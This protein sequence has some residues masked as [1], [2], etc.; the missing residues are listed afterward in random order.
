ME[1]SGDKERFIAICRKLYNDNEKELQN[2]EDFA[3]NYSPAEA[4]KWYTR[5]TF[6]YRILNHALRVQSVV[7]LFQMK[8]FI[9]D[10]H[11]HLKLL[12]TYEK[13]QSSMLLYRGQAMDNNEFNRLQQNIGGF[14][15]INSFL[16]TSLRRNIALHFALQSSVDRA[17]VTP[18][19]FEMKVDTKKSPKPFHNISQYSA[20]ETEQEI[21]FSVGTVFHIESVQKMKDGVWVVKLILDGEEDKE[22]KELTELLRKEIHASNDLF[23]LG[24]LT[25]RMGEYEFSEQLYSSV[26]E[27]LSENHPDRASALS[28]LGSLLMR[29]GSHSEALDCYNKCLKWEL[30]HSPLNFLAHAATYHN[31]GT[32]YAH[33][34]DNEKAL[35]YFEKAKK[36]E[37]ELLPSNTTSIASTYNQMAAVYR[38]MGDFQNALLYAEKALSIQ[39][40]SLPKNHL[41]KAM[42]LE[43]LG[44]IYEKQGDVQKGLEYFLKSLQMETI[45][46]P[47]LHPTL[48]HSHCNIG[49]TYLNLGNYPEA[50]KHFK[51][52]YDI[53][54][55]IDHPLQQPLQTLILLSFTQM[56]G[57]NIAELLSSA[58]E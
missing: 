52:S 5:D 44:L 12:H 2:I 51:T 27:N 33:L 37:E 7:L 3:Q 46:L 14:L 13:K 34:D 54:S 38:D 21:L 30:A 24:K 4:I 23:T 17:D 36:I 43:N 10:I 49:Q 9:Q 19:L 57:I 22:L 41:E 42:S 47:A 1:A 15:S 35:S 45:V 50:L 40:T 6:L 26:V 25:Y 16:S 8:F 58:E 39:Q 53:A 18:I 55:A 56:A 48:I 29:K 20:F 32:A 31:I 28:N 11:N